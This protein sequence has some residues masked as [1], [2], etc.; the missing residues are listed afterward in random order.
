VKKQPTQET[1]YRLLIE[2]VL[3][4]RDQK[5]RVA[6]RLE[7]TKHFTA[8]Q[9]E[10]AVQ[11]SIDDHTILFRLRGL[12]APSLSLPSTGPAQFRKEYDALKGVYEIVVE[13]IDG[14]KNIFRVQFKTR[15]ITL[16]KQPRQR[17]V[18]VIVGSTIVER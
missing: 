4:E 17:F 3:S 14:T 2:P 8:F 10:I 11:D 12:K 6:F 18:E 5:V 9:Y 15:S 13:S 1:E 16:L 7:T